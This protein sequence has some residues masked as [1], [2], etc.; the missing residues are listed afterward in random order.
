LKADDID[1]RCM[2]VPCAFCEIVAER[3]PASFIFRDDV[4]SAFMSIQPTAAG[5]CLII[6]NEHIDHFTD[7]PDEVA[8]RIMTL[9]QRIGRRM[10]AV[11]PLERVGYLVHGYG[12]AHAHFM[13]VPQQGPHHLTSDRLARLADG[14]IVFDL[15]SIKIAERATLDEQARLLSQ[16]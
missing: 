11:F 8:E 13:I 1:C 15:S 14:R 12:V 3:A 4:I 6:P 16:L 7:I 10:R 5:E 9:A 2:S